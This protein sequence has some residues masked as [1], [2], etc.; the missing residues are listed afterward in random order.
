MNL[1]VITRKCPNF[2]RF[3]G[4]YRLKDWNNIDIDK[5]TTDVDKSYD[6]VL[7]TELNSH[8]CW[9]VKVIATTVL[10]CN[11]YM[12]IYNTYHICIYCDCFITWNEYT[13]GSWELRQYLRFGMEHLKIISIRLWNFDFYPNISQI[14]VLVKTSQIHQFQTHQFQTNRF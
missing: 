12:Y 5:G 8:L 14:W 6:A 11:M 1:N 3:V 7:L 2:K 9:T 10:T 4:G 13:W